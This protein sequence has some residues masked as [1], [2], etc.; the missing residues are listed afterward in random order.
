MADKLASEPMTG[1]RVH[2]KL[3]PSSGRLLCLGSANFAGA[4]LGAKSEPNAPRRSTGKAEDRHRCLADAR[5]ARARE[6]GAAT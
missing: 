6:K 3:M 5:K 2:L 4:G 1:P